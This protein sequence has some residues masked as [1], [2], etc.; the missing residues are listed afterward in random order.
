MALLSRDQ[1]L[2]ADDLPTEDIEVPEWGGCVRL[3]TLTGEERDRFEASSIKGKGRNRGVNYDN[4]RARLVA[5]CAI[6][7]EGN[8]LFGE[9]DVRKLG[10]KSAA[11]LDRLFDAASR[12]NGIG[13]SDVE[14][15]VEDFTDAPSGPSTT[16]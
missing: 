3:R 7:E 14:D 10:Q 8:P 16:G 6:N 15:L 5:R 4:L 11:A 1:I 9:A 2:G 13:E 12:M